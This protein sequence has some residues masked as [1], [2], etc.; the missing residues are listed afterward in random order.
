MPSKTLTLGTGELDAVD[1][2]AAVKDYIA[3]IDRTLERNKRTQTRIDRLK[4]ETREILARLK[5]QMR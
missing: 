2:A 1:A 3:R 4:T 5:A